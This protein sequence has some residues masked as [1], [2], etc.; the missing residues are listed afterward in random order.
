M[1]A[2]NYSVVAGG[3]EFTVEVGRIAKQASGAC[4]VGL[5]ET[6][7]LV[8]AQADA[9]QGDRD[10]MPL[11]VH[12][13]EFQYAAGKIPGGFFKRE[14]RPTDKE[15]L[16]SRMIDR[17]IRPLMPEGWR[18]ETQ[19]LANVLSADRVNDSAI[20][21]IF[22]ASLALMLSDIP[23]DGPVAGARIGRVDGN[24]ILNPTVDERDESDMDIIL[25]ASEDSIVMVE[26]GADFLSE[27][28]I[29]DALL[30]GQK[31]V[32][33]LIELQKQIAAENGKTKRE[34][35]AP[36]PHPDA[37][38]FVEQ[39]RGAIDEASQIT[40]KAERYGKLDEVKADAKAK[41]AEELSEEA[42]AWVS[43]AFGD[44]KKE[45]IRKRMVATKTRIDGRG[46]TDVRP[47]DIDLGFLKRPHASALFQRGE[48][49]AIVTATLG[50]TEDEKKAE[51]LE[52]EEYKKFYLHYNFPPYS[53]G[54]VRRVGSPGRRE[55]GHGALAERAL[56]KTL[57]IG[58]SSRTRSAWSARLRSQT[59]PARWRLVCGGSLA[60]MSGGVPIR[61]GIAGIAMGLIQ[62]GDDILVLS[63]ILGDE[64]HLGDMDF[65]VAGGRSG[66]T[67]LQMDIKIDGITREV[68]VNA[69]QQALE[70]R[71]HILGRMED[72][73]NES[74]EDVSRYA[75]RVLSI[76]IPV[77][78][79]RDVIGPGGKVIRGI[80]EETGAK[81]DIDDD[82]SVRIYAADGESAD[83]AKSAIRGL[84]REVKEGD[85]YV[86]TV[87][88]TVDF[89]AFVE[90]FPGTDGL[91]HI[92]ELEEGRV[93]KVEDVIKQGDSVVVKV[94]KVEPNGKIRLSRRA[95][96]HV[97]AEQVEEM[98]AEVQA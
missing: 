83:M 12:Y 94:L 10:F 57:Q 20:P 17:P 38:A 64:D 44:L 40:T 15:T 50:T 95:A 87:V 18:A 27:D 41:A 1:Q 11:T 70:G 7:V 61:E 88:K 36:E 33:P 74:A 24:L 97:T 39:F 53:V 86:G 47:I 13:T 75:P 26:G 77:N 6:Q 3:K 69:L 92:S 89:G 34:F 67:S 42:L 48:T 58:T 14:G 51:T 81:I 31:E 37:V 59:A 80:V 45:V 54:E 8:T 22:G 68:L 46:L 96:A 49:Q 91:V 76:N 60:M 2:K 35:V 9:K 63:D 4:L 93:E 72:Y 55:I 52:Y 5:G 43:T 71:L 98:N 28:E 32:Q 29:V 16:T 85:F 21:A 19:V 66:I 56:E 65:K 23:F 82:G 62:E 30:F 90:L 84:T 25:V 79:I 78:K 73:I